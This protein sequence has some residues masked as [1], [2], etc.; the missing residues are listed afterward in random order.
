MCKQVLFTISRFATQGG[1]DTTYVCAN[2]N[3]VVKFIGAVL[4]NGKLTEKEVSSTCVKL[5]VGAEM[6]EGILLVATFHRV[7]C[8]V[9]YN[10]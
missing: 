8:H 7:A 5:I 3:G 9:H 6:S 1:N 10:T 4:D 2:D